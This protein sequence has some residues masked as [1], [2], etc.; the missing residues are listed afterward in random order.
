MI[1]NQLSAW[2]VHFDFPRILFIIINNEKLTLLHYAIFSTISSYSHLIHA[3]GWGDFVLAVAEFLAIFL[4][5][6]YIGVIKKDRRTLCGEF[7]SSGWSWGQNLLGWPATVTCWLEMA[8]LGFHCMALWMLAAIKSSPCSKPS[9]LSE[10]F[11]LFMLYI[12]IY[13]FFCIITV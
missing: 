10:I 7:L 13:L 12:V 6:I 2:S 1:L 3:L 4:C 5:L 11:I 8:I 9:L